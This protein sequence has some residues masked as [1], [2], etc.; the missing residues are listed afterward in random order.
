MEATKTQAE[1]ECRRCLKYPRCDIPWKDLASDCSGRE[2]LGPGEEWAHGG[3]PKITTTG[4][5]AQLAEAKAQ[6]DRVAAEDLVCPRV[7][8]T[9]LHV[10][11]ESSG[12]C[13]AAVLAGLLKIPIEDVPEFS[14]SG[15][16]KQVN[17]FLRPYGLAWLQIAIDSDWLDSV[18]VSGM[19]HEVSGDT[20]RFGGKVRHACAAIDCTV[21]WD[22]HPSQEGLAVQDG[23]SIFVALRP[24]E[25]A[26]RNLRTVPSSS[27]LGEWHTPDQHPEWPEPEREGG[28][29]LGSDVSVRVLGW[30][31]DWGWHP[32]VLREDDDTEPPRYFWEDP[33]D[34]FTPEEL[35]ERLRG[36]V[37]LPL[38]PSAL[39]NNQG[40]NAT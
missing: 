21:A 25:T 4:S 3:A 24:W 10:P 31:E 16:Q 8:Q 5:R 12:N 13:F 1:I 27:V 14:G 40:G 11:G 17:A 23:A 26:Q 36:W 22:P 6:T 20:T 37:S 30:I 9:I 38:E 7:E 2:P 29:V 28:L 34:C 15:W 19:W 32:V 33:I 39:R 35:S 18:G